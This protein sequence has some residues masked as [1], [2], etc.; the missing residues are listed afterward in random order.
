ML[1]VALAGTISAA[2]LTLGGK[3]NRPHTS[4]PSAYGHLQTLVD[5]VDE[6]HPKMYWGHKKDNHAGT[7]STRLRDVELDMRYG[8]CDRT[9]C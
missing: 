8:Y 6:W 7:S 3:L 2:H 4:Q 1:Y 5:L 9:G